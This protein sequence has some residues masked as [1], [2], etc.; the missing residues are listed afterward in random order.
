[1]SAHPEWKSSVE[2]PRSFSFADRSTASIQDLS[3]SPLMCF[4][5]KD[6][7]TVSFDAYIEWDGTL[8]L[9]AHQNLR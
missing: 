3:R 4:P 2:E 6:V 9:L 8:K 7:E 1:M 5:S